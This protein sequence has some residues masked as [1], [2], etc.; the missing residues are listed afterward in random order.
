MDRRGGVVV[1]SNLNPWVGWPTN[2]RIITT[3]EVLP[4]GIR[5]LCPTMGSVPQS[6]VPE[7]WAPRASGFEDQWCLFSGD[8]EDCGK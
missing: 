1:E 3:A 6:C 2:G 7:R 5:G 4:Q 8:S